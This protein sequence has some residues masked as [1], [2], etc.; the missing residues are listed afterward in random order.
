MSKWQQH[1]HWLPSLLLARADSAHLLGDERVCTQVLRV[2]WVDAAHIL[3]EHRDRLRACDSSSQPQEGSGRGER[4]SGGECQV[5]AM[6]G[7]PETGT[8]LDVEQVLAAALVAVHVARAGAGPEAYVLPGDVRHVHLPI[9][10]SRLLLLLLCK[11]RRRFSNGPWNQL[12]IHSIQDHYN[13][14]HDKLESLTIARTSALEAHT[15]TLQERGVM[16][17]GHMSRRRRGITRVE[18]RPG[19]GLGRLGDRGRRGDAP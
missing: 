13:P 5:Y 14:T 2:V 11:P 9:L 12:P 3:H 1:W 18:R 8:S 16:D 4:P 7:L 17:N 19:H 6:Q 10:A 15:S